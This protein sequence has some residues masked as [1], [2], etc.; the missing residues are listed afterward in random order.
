VVVFRKARIFQTPIWRRG[1]PPVKGETII[2]KADGPTNVYVLRLKGG[3]LDV[4]EGHVVI[5][6]GISNEI[7]RR[8]RPVSAAAPLTARVSP[9]SQALFRE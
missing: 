8:L 4:P 6:I 3:L 1:P 9:R 5:K 2:S 7:G